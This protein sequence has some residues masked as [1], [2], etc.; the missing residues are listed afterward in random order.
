MGMAV[1][2]MERSAASG[3]DLRE[4]VADALERLSQTLVAH[5]ATDMM[6]VGPVSTASA[7]THVQE[8]VRFLGQVIA[9]W[10]DVP[11][12]AFRASGAGFGSVVTVEDLDQGERD[13]FTLMAG[14]LIAPSKCPIRLPP[15][16]GSNR[17]GIS[18][19]CTRPGPRRRTVRSAARRPSSSGGSRSARWR[20]LWLA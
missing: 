3:A 20:A 8:A 7:M 2:R 15:I 4:R 18:P 5:T 11:E 9:A 6:R 14:P 17:I 16:R 12:D 13:V 19:L 1:Y 10:D